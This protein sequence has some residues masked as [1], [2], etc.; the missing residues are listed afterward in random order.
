MKADWI[1]ARQTKYTVYVIVYV[2]IVLG[3][4]G[5]ANF[6]AQRYNKSFDS[7]S[8]KR[9][10]LSDQTI[11][12]V[13]GLKEDLKI[14]YW[15]RTGEFTRARDTLDR[16]K[17]LSPKVKVEYSD[18]EKKATQARAA[19]VKNYGTI[20]IETAGK[21]EEAKTLSEEELTGAIVRVLKGGQRTACFV[22][23][24]GEHSLDD[25]GRSGYSSA[26][27]LIE[28]NNYKTQALKLLEKNEIPKEC[29]L[30]VVAGP[31]RDYVQPVVDTLKKY[32]EEGGRLLVMI[33]PPLK[34]GTDEI[35]ENAA[36]VSVLQGWGVTPKKNLVLDTSGIGQIFGL[37]EV[38]PL[39]ASYESHAI[40]REMKEVATAFPLAR[41]L[42]VKN[43]DKTTVEKLFN[44]SDNSFATS[45]LAKAEIER[46]P[47][48]EKGPLTLGAAG[49]F[50]TGKENANGRFVVV[51]SSG[52]AANN[53]LRFNGNRDLLLNM[54]NWLS[55]DEDLISIRPKEPEDRRISMSRR[56]MN[57]L[58]YGSVLFLPAAVVIFG[59]GVWWRRR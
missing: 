9:F 56:Q 26:K 22:L 41:S 30:A 13:K 19:G 52:W 45:N 29:T 10:S 1:K 39:V 23:G 46:G 20:F 25:S 17:N 58:F 33:D 12:V 28:R 44:T 16:Y 7:T 42:E 2:A 38:V 47:N 11:K 51:G 57:L 50:N 49:T 8:N 14:S 37:S 53:I 55:S 18:P 15:D 48:D 6:L 59:L 36:L 40:V 4:I 34:I 3:V 27:E 43:G 31:R 21:K 24:S 32:L 54:L 5:F 35:D